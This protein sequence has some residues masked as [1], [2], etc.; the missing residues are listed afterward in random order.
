MAAY[1]AWL[2]G[3]PAEHGGVLAA[4][5]AIA[6]ATWLLL[7]MAV[8]VNEFSLN[9]FYRNRLV[10]CYLGA[11]NAWRNPE[12]TTN[13]DVAD[14]LPL[15]RLVEGAPMADGARPLFPLIC[16]A[17]NLSLIHI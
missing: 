4:T 6:A 1:L 12:P 2:A 16:T 9:A 7:A 15:H 14:D 13:F 17:L 3:Y 5:I 11:S 10:R 8:N